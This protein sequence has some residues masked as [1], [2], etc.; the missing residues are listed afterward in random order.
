MLGASTLQRE[1]N[2]LNA[3]LFATFYRAFLECDGEVQKGILEMIHLVNSVETDPDDRIMAI[4]TISE[5]LFP[6]DDCGELGI[7]VEEADKGAVE[8]CDDGHIGLKELE[9]EERAFAQRLTDAMKEKGLTQ[10]QLAERSG[11]GQPAISM[12]LSRN[13]RPQQR[14]VC[15]LAE[16]LGV[17]PSE[18]WEVKDLL[19]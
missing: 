10:K 8:N 1:T 18:L 19:P 15:K 7:D 9:E 14:T 11:V 5:A 3:Q 4:R 12:M 17:A 16:A 6:E 13:C 2:L